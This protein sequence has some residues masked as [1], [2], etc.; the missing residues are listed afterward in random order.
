[1]W[2][3]GL[4]SAVMKR[5]IWWALVNVAVCAVSSDYG[6]GHLVGAV[7]CGGVGFIVRLCIGTV[8][9]HC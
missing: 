7:E 1:M 5:D 8:G 3:Y 4:E 9:G 2:R 6:E